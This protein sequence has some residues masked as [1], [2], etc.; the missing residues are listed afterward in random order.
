MWILVLVGRVDAEVEKSELYKLVWFR[1]EAVEETVDFSRYDV[2]KIW[3]HENP[4]IRSSSTIEDH[5]FTCYNHRQT[6]TLTSQYLLDQGGW[7]GFTHH[8]VD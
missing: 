3:W 8:D 1:H 7:S 6:H 4:A 2:R 5:T